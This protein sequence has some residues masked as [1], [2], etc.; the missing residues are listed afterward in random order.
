MHTAVEFGRL[1]A[2]CFAHNPASLSGI[3]AQSKVIK[4]YVTRSAEADQVGQFI[5]VN[6][7]TKKRLPLRSHLIVNANVEDM[8]SFLACSFT[9]AVAAKALG[10]VGVSTRR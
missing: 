1:L 7:L 9:I 2:F 3:N 8:G 6:E 10:V 5:Y 4:F